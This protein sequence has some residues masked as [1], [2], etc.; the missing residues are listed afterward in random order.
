MPFNS[1]SHRDGWEASHFAFR[2]AA[3]AWARALG[4]QRGPAVYNGLKG[5]KESA[6]G[7]SK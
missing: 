1:V 5:C 3:R 7:G 4:R 2:S 6:Y